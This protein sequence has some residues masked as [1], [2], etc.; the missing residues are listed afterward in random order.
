MVGNASVKR[1]KIFRK[2]FASVKRRKIFKLK[3]ALNSLLVSI[4]LFYYV[5][6]RGSGKCFLVEVPDRRAVTLK[7][8]IVQYILPGTHIISDGWAT[9]AQ[10]ENINHG[11]YRL[12][13]IVHHEHFVDPNDDAIHTQNV[14]NL[15][16][17]VKRKLRR[18]F[19]TSE[20]LF[21][22]HLHEFVWRER[23]KNSG[24]FS[25]FICSLTRQHT[26]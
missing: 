16:M 22:S 15:W 14:E 20:T 2:Y 18:Q 6:E 13:V 5:F 9:Y 25:A 17:R 10:I 11:I 24:A 26:F 4:I 8:A 1:R 21:T 23:Q 12:D 19:G 7:E 3:N